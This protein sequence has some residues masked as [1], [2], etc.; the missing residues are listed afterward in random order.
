MSPLEQASLLQ[1]AQHGNKEAFAALYTSF[2][3][4]IFRFVYY[5]THHQETA[6]DLVAHIF[7]KALANLKTCEPS[8]GTFSTWLYQIARHT[9]V[10][11]YR[12]Q[13]QTVDIE[14]AWDIKNPDDLLGQVAVQIEFARLK[15]YLQHLSGEQ[16]DI[17]TMRIWQELSYAEIAA[18]LSKS[19]ASCKMS[20]GRAIKQ[21]Q[22][23]MPLSVFVALLLFH[24]RIVL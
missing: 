1:E 8:K 3:K 9:V 22:Q 19:E 14:D 4:P 10:D 16:R 17:I 6:E 11:H 12:T 2:V 23:V 21:L 7:T 18:I 13:K 24:H 15:K 20:F 5:K